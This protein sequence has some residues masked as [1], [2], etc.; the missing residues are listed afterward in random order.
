[1]L[2]HDTS[3]LGRRIARL[4]SERIS[5]RFRQCR[6][7]HD[8][9][10]HAQQSIWGQRSPIMRSMELIDSINCFGFLRLGVRVDS[11]C[12]FFIFPWVLGLAGT[13]GLDG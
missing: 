8:L 3:F 11:Y 12:S 1:M 2:A 10:S 13:E 6:L 7:D 5:R 4:V 9:R